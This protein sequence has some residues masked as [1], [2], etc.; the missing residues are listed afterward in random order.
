M[1]FALSQHYQEDL[2]TLVAR[3]HGDPKRWIESVAQVP[4]R[5]GLK[6]FFEPE[7]LD[8]W[9]NLSLFLPIVIL[10]CVAALSAIALLLAI[11]G[12]YGTIFYSVSERRREIGIR[13]ALGARPRQLFSMVLKRTALIAGFGVVAGTAL[14]IA[15]TVILRSQFFGIRGVEWFVLLPVAIA[16]IALALAVALAAARPWIR[17]N[18]MEAVRHV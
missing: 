3:T 11:V 8:E 6:L 7:T 10:R 4:R 18:P 14:G 15:A 13:V 2:I 16:M 5:L 9:M 17:M 12:L 1:Y